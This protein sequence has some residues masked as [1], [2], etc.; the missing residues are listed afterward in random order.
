VYNPVL[1][2][3]KPPAGGSD[4]FSCTWFSSAA[5]FGINAAIENYSVGWIF[6]TKSHRK[7]P[8]MTHHKANSDGMFLKRPRK[9]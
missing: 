4:A 5:S 2:P 9:K 1:K 8:L 6:S 7:A 3:V